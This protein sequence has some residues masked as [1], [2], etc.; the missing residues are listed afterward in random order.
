MY[1]RNVSTTELR[2]NPRENCQLFRCGV[3]INGT[4]KNYCIPDLLLGLKSFLKWSNSDFT[5]ALSWIKG[6]LS[7]MLIYVFPHFSLFFKYLS[8]S[9]LVSINSVDT[10]YERLGF[11]FFLNLSLRKKCPYSEL[12]WSVF[13][14]IRTEYGE[15]QS[16]SPCSVRT[17]ENM[18]QN[19][20]EYGHFSRRV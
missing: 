15:I 9:D 13:F 4:E 2:I 14:P 7:S 16:I 17:R 8:M 10:F 12:F 11:D 1:A 6:V 18:D 20:S 3:C 19:N 5:M